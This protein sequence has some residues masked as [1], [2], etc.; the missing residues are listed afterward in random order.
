[1]KRVSP[2][3]ATAILILSSAALAQQAPQSSDKVQQQPPQASS[4]KTPA[5][6]DAQP[7]SNNATS[8][9][10]TQS[11]SPAQSDQPDDP[12]K[13]Q[14]K[15]T[16]KTQDGKAVSGPKDATRSEKDKS[17]K[18]SDKTP[19]DSTE[20]MDPNDPLFGVPPLP[21]GDVSLIGGTV[22]KVDRLRNRVAIRTFGDGGKK[23]TVAFDERSHIYRDGVETTERGIRQGDRIYVDTMLDNGRLFARNI[24]VVTN[25]KPTD[26][27]GQIVAYDPGSGQ[28]SV[29]D[30]L[31]TTTIN[32]QIAHD[33]IV[34]GGGGQGAMELVPGS[35]VNVRFSPDA[36]SRA[37]AR[38]ID[39]LAEP[40]NMFTF[41]GKVRYLDMSR[42]MIAVENVTDNK[43]YELQFDPG[44]VNNNI[45]VGSDVSVAA[46]FNGSGYKAK[47]V[48]VN[49]ARN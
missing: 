5:Q 8:P 34:K 2:L 36:R 24:R 39:I 27:R 44:V 16:G 38:E 45:T 6:P 21:K 29:R 42:R 12:S 20:V 41:A 32:F 22:Q 13:V 9:T 40:G 14:Q 43:T 3:F 49:Q 31:T 17:D 37:T 18:G 23:M 7:A 10:A 47:T 35:L 15:D 28:M 1:M 30:E 46:V 19:P 4:D 26:A 48:A 33:T 25:L 11:S